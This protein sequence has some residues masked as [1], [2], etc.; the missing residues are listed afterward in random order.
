VPDYSL[1]LAAEYKSAAVAAVDVLVVVVSV[2]MVSAVSTAPVVVP[3]VHT[4]GFALD[5]PAG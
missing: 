4:I 3:A 1:A 2:A 5:K